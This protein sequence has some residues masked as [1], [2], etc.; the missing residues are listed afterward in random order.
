M[1]DRKYLTHKN[2]ALSVISQKVAD[3]NL[4]YSFVI[5]KVSVRNQKTRWGSCSIKGNLSFNYKI[6]FLPEHIRDYIIVHELCHLKEFNH[7]RRF[8]ELVVQSIPDYRE[9]RR[10]LKKHSYSLIIP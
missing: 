3:L 9:I 10:I 7:S 8:W 5:T 6:A 1:N 2:Y 4:H